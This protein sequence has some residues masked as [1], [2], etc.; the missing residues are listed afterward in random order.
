MLA[1]KI[2]KQA[3]D[4]L[5]DTLHERWALDEKIQGLNY[6]QNLVVIHRPDS[7]VN[8]AARQLTAGETKQTIP[9]DGIRFMK[10]VRNM[11]EAG[12]TPGTVITHVEM[13]TFNQEDPD[14]HTA[15]AATVIEHYLY[16]P[17]DPLNYYVYPP[18]HGSTAVYVDEVYSQVPTDV[19]DQA[20]GYVA[21][22]SLIGLP[23]IYSNALLEFMLYLMFLKDEEAASDAKAAVHNGHAL[24]MLGVKSQKDF[25]FAPR[26]REGP[27]DDRRPKPESTLV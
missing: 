27:F 3:S 1:S 19:P 12:S 14:W 25:L 6:A 5:H 23:D 22:T 11:G 20:G 4:Q 10:L 15:P 8:N 18:V 13:D 26:V 21:D 17:A 2:I 24:Q 16:D 7:N 9:S